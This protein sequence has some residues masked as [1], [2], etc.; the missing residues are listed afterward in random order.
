MNI[1]SIQS[2][3][4]YGHVG[5]SAAVFPLQRLG[6]EVW[7]V[8]TVHFSNHPG[9][10]AHTGT[11]VAPAAIAALIAG[12]EARGALARCDALL[13]GYIGD[14][15]T[16][17]VMRDAADRVRNAN[18]AALWCCDPVMGDQAPG[19]Y[20]R[21]GIPDFFRDQAV[22]AADLL[23]PNLF[24]LGLLTGLPCATLA[25]T[26]AAAGALLD[27]MRPSGPRAILVT[28]VQ[29]EDT[30]H[31][32]LDL[33]V[34]SPGACH[35]LRTPLLPMAPNGAGDA[36]AALFLFHMLNGGDAAAAMANAAA[37][38]HGI[39]R[40]TLEAGSRELVLIEA[41]DELVRPTH[42]FEL[43]SC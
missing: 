33:L 14:E 40:R 26:Q 31:D 28:S 7:P 11:V 6:A 25:E 22:P 41:Q 21:A 8:S 39:L 42:R 32:A 34:V 16:G 24:E 36:M 2:A 13:T 35:R 20:V 17:T 30:P 4:A 18:P 5:N 37:S 15:G 29:V 38:V 23:T 10:G 12:I 9:Y 43:E 3:V 19:I 27:R 1:L